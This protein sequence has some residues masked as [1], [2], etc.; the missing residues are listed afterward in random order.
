MAEEEKLTLVDKIS[1][2]ISDA[3]ESFRDTVNDVLDRITGKESSI[4]VNLED[5][6]LQVG[7]EQR[8][9]ATGSIKISL[10]LLK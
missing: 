9:G 7:E 6:G 5:V 10:S 8:F 2:A 1:D 3:T 4:S